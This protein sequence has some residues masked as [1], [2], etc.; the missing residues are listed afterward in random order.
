MRSDYKIYADNELVKSLSAG[1]EGAFQELYS[2]YWEPLFSKSGYLPAGRKCGEGLST[3]SVLL[4]VDGRNE[5]RKENPR[6]YLLQATRF[7][8][9][10]PLRGQRVAGGFETGYLRLPSMS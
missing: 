10:N 9:L 2:R 3:G 6:N 7:Q 5:L 8:A 4:V 1:Q